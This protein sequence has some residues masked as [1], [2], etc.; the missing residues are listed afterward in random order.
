MRS[1]EDHRPLA[2][3]AFGERREG[4]APRGELALQRAFG[5]VHA[6]RHLVERPE[7]AVV[8]PEQPPHAIDE[9]RVVAELVQR[10]L[11]QGACHAEPGRVGG[12]DR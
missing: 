4:H 8:A 12:D 2:P 1:Q 3:F 10:A 11:A 9:P 7:A 6:R 5:D